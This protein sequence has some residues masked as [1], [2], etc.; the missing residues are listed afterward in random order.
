MANR[1]H[2]G[3]TDMKTSNTFG[4]EN[5]QVVTNVTAASTV[6]VW[7]PPKNATVTQNYHPRNPM[8]VIDCL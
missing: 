4:P 2:G 7:I 6:T 3:T 1:F 8:K 5:T